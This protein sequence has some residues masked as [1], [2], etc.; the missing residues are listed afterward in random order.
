[1]NTPDKFQAELERDRRLDELCKRLSK[2]QD[3]RDISDDLSGHDS[4]MVV[5][6]I[7]AAKQKAPDSEE[8]G[9]QE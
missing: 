8:T 7:K 1:M 3:F 6:G 5:A 4:F 9:A 2:S